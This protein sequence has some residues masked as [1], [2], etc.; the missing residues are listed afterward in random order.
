[1]PIT[2]GR[3]AS[4]GRLNTPIR[5]LRRKSRWRRRPLQSMTEV[6]REIG[7]T[8]FIIQTKAF[9]PFFSPARVPSLSRG[10]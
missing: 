4:G 5:G 1:M 3:A 6:N 8:I 2:S 10:R 9:H 7:R